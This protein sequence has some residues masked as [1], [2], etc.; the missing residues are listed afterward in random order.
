MTSLPV[1]SPLFFFCCSRCT[2]LTITKRK[3][4]NSFSDLRGSPI[5]ARSALSIRERSFEITVKRER[6]QYFAAKYTY[7]P[8]IGPKSTKKTNIPPIDALKARISALEGLDAMMHGIR[9]Q[10]R[11]VKLSD[12]S[13]HWQM[14][15]DY[16]G[17]HGLLSPRVLAIL[18]TSKI[19]RLALTESTNDKAGLN[20]AGK[21][22]LSVSPTA[23]FLSELSFNGTRVQL[24][25]HHPRHSHRHAR[26]P[27]P[28]QGHQRRATDHPNSSGRHSL[29]PSSANGLPGL[30]TPAID[31]NVQRPRLA[32][33]HFRDIQHSFSNSAEHGQCQ[34]KRVKLVLASEQEY[35]VICEDSMQKETVASIPGKNAPHVTTSFPWTEATSNLRSMQTYATSPASRA[36]SSPAEVS[37]S[38]SPF[39]FFGGLR[40]SPKQRLQLLGLCR[41]TAARAA[42]GL[43]SNQPLGHR[44]DQAWSTLGPRCGVSYVYGLQ[45]TFEEDIETASSHPTSSSS[46]ILASTVQNGFN[47]SEDLRPQRKRISDGEEQPVGECDQE[48][49]SD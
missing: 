44:P 34:L 48:Q 5:H 26:P 35:M 27:S 11:L 46:P 4:T 13:H 6:L 45:G 37:M 18:R 7:S 25:Q 21:S 43:G 36:V 31:K 47:A 22:L 14:I 3:R 30:C 41:Q 32:T 17:Q 38:Q 40:A 42:L 20:I 10:E 15:T 29:L 1:P 49:H 23:S 28:G 33:C 8:F 24:V 2:V 19:W 12:L 16:L 9:L 39:V